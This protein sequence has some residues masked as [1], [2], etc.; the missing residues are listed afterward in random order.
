MIAFQ[1]LGIDAESDFLHICPGRTPAVA[2]VFCADG[3][4]GGLSM[5]GDG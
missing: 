3:G 2:G 1:Q 5:E 4:G